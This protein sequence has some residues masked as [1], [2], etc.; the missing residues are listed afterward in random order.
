M[1][2]AATGDS[3]ILTKPSSASSTQSRARVRYTAALKWLRRIHLY[4]GLFMTPWVFLYGI[5]GFLFNH[6]DAFS[7]RAV[8]YAGRAELK[9]TALEDFPTAPQM[10]EDLVK[11]LNSRD[12]VKEYRLI[13]RESSAL[14]RTLTI[15]ATGKGE[16]HSVRFDPDSSDVLIRSMAGKNKSAAKWPGKPS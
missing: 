14:S 15:T 10:A 8:R 2:Q 13:D 11:T 12:G 4:S 1:T 16:E 6:P 5:T 7:D 9:G 3:S